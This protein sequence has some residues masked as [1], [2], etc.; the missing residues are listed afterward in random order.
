VISQRQCQLSIRKNTLWNLLGSAS[1]MLVGVVAIPYLLTKLG[2][3]RLGVLTLIWALIGYFSIFDF[4]LGRA[5]TYKVSSLKGRGR[6][7]R[8]WESITS[9]LILLTGV[10]I[11]GVAIVTALVLL[12]GVHWLNVSPHVYEE[13]KM[14]VLI[15]GV[16]IPITTITSGLKGILEG[17]ENFRMAN[18]LKTLLGFANFLIPVATVRFFGANLGFVVF[19]LLMVRLTVM[20][21]HVG[22]VA[23][24]LRV[25]KA[26]HVE[27]GDDWKELAKF[28][29]WMTVSN[30]LSPFMVVSDRFIIS[31]FLGGAIVA[32]YA[33]PNDFLFRLLI[34]PGALTTTLFPVFAQRLISEG[35]GVRQL[36][37][38]ALRSIAALMLPLTVIIALF[39]HYGLYLWL[40]KTFADKSYVVVILLVV[41]IL[42]N[43]LA[44]IPHA[45]IQASGDVRKTSLVHIAEFVI[46]MPVLIV[47]VTRFGII[48]AALVWQLRVIADFLILH[49][50]A[51]RKFS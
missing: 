44:Q 48:G 10:G 4:G 23:K 42:F 11:V 16:A 47:A 3:E 46:Y 50:L 33:I 26:S 45:M 21:L 31:H 17:L 7:D 29:A 43:S 5:L 36:Y 39:S 51:I 19:G 40:G 27:H 8:V 41:G 37:Y 38:K 25:F 34:L 32:Y 6:V 30:V 13:T 49:S 15:A 24:S 2:V 1:P 12:V 20:L 14:A 22:V 35:R 28:G 18:I 9:G